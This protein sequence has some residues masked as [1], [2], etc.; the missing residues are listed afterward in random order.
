VSQPV[1]EELQG[2]SRRIREAR[3]RAELTLQ[4]LA[5]RSGVATSSIQKVET[6]QMVPS[7][8]VVMKIARGLGVRAGELVD[9]AGNDEVSLVH[10]RPQDRHPVG[11]PG[12][13]V[14]ERMSGDLFAPALETWRVTI[15]PGATSG[16]AELRYDG[17]EWVLC[18][19]GSVTFVVAGTA[20]RMRAG[21]TLH[22]KA[23]L[24]HAWRN[25]GSVAARFLVTGTVPE[26]LRAALAHRFGPRSTRHAAG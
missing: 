5:H 25:D 9:G 15:H 3:E 11:K 12:E 10:L 1:D 8:A 26:K 16:K 22:F 21:D 23:S 24:P 6:G 20:H 2:I 13:L 19:K 14:V 4:E 7:V 17:E 18:E